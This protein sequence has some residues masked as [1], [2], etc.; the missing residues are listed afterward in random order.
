MELEKL[1]ELIKTAEK[2]FDIYINE[3]GSDDIP[4]IALNLISWQK[5]LI[6]IMENNK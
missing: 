5:E 1:E 3:Y 6:E 4:L 2:A